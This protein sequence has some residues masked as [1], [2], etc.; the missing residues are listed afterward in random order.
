MARPLRIE[1][2]GEFYHVINRGNA[3]GHI[4]KNKR[5]KEKFLKYL[6]KAVDRFSIVIHTY[7]LMDSHYHLLMETPVPNLSVAVQWMNVSYA[8][9][10][11]GKRQRI[12]GLKVRS[13]R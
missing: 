2:P 7:C 9:Y 12:R 13:I 4:F 1:Y 10:F 5:D 8:D 6:E 3:G 11:N